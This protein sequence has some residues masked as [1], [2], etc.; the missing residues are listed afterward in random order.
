M[1]HRSVPC[2]KVGCEPP[3]ASA[4]VMFSGLFIHHGSFLQ[5]VFPKPTCKTAMWD[6][7]ISLHRAKIYHIYHFPYPLDQ[8]SCQGEKIRLF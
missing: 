2:S 4:Q 8:L 5:T 1:Q 6:Y 7:V 3:R